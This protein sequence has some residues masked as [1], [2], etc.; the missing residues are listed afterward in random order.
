MVEYNAYCM[1]LGYWHAAYQ[2]GDAAAV[3]AAVTML[4]AARAWETLSDPL[5]TDQAFRLG[6]QRTID[7]AERGDAAV[8]L[9]ELELNC[10]G[11]W[12]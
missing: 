9:R 7:A 11:T 8:I 4:R 12:P 2:R 6:I 10:Q 3:S 5:T 1:W